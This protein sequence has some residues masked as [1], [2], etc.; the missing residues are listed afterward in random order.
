MKKINKSEKIIGSSRVKSE[1]ITRKEAIKKAGK[2]AAFTAAATLMILNPKEAQAF[3]PGATPPP[4]GW[5]EI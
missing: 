2:Y 5:L 4:P 1:K 3:S